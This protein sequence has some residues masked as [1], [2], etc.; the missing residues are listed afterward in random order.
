MFGG[1]K[2]AERRLEEAGERACARVVKC[3]RGGTW[4]VNGAHGAPDVQRT[5]CRLT[6]EVQPSGGQSFETELK[7]HFRTGSVP[8]EGDVID[9]VYDPSDHDKVTVAGSSG[10]GGVQVQVV[11]AAG[12]DPT[13]PLPQVTVNGEVI[14]MG[15]PP[16]TDVADEIA[17]LGELRD[18][19]LLTDT[20]FQAQKQK[21]LDRL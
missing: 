3:D 8:S 13:R 6:L 17:K 15:R 7:T 19:G 2:R 21:L 10:G 9:V 18:Q 12:G 5:T 4:W 1:K 16:V 14:S 11:R 20:E